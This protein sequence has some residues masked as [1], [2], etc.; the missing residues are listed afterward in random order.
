MKSKT[1]K[2]RLL[3]NKNNTGNIRVENFDIKNSDWEK[4]LGVKFDHKQSYL[5]FM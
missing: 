1:N 2:C 4:R 3:V 5:K